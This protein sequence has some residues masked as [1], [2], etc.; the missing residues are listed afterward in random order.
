M[1]LHPKPALNLALCPKH[2]KP[3]TARFT[4]LNPENEKHISYSLNSLMGG[5]YKE[6]KGDYYRGY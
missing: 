4:G 5:L 6:D 2:V 3:Q 1:V